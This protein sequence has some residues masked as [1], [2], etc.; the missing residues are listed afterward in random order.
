V[1]SQE[2]TE[3]AKTFQLRLAADTR[4]FKIME[5]IASLCKSDVNIRSKLMK[6]NILKLLLQLVQVKD[7][8][9]QLHFL[10]CFKHFFTVGM[11]ITGL[12][13]TPY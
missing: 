13:I 3:E 6:C 10:E 4:V 9:V 2:E 1:F 12:S 7:I 5:I 8:A 11:I